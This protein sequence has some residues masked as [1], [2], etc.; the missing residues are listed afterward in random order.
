MSND[1]DSE[2][3]VNLLTFYHLSERAFAYHAGWERE[4]ALDIAADP[5]RFHRRPRRASRHHQ[6]SGPAPSAH[7][8]HHRAPEYL[9]HWSIASSLCALLRLASRVHVAYDAAAAAGGHAFRH[10]H[11]HAFHRAQFPRQSDPATI[12]RS[13]RP[14][15]PA[16]DARRPAHRASPARAPDRSHGPLDRH[17]A[18]RSVAACAL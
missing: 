16:P 5:L 11:L 18:A 6:S 7:I 1:N 12:A 8:A 13:C 15:R 14:R 4:R 3:L 2:E 9:P 10:V 17:P